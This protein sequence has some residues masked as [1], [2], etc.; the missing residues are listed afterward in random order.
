MTWRSRGFMLAAYITWGIVVGVGFTKLWRYT[1]TPGIEAATSSS[2]PQN[3]R[4]QRA[5]DRPTLVLS[6]SPGCPCSQAAVRELARVVARAPARAAIRMIFDVTSSDSDSVVA[7]Q[8]GRLWRMANDIPGVVT[9]VDRDGSETAAFGANASGQAFLYDAAGR[10]RFRGRIT[11]A[12]G[13]NVDN[14][15]DNGGADSLVALLT[16]SK[17]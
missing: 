1:Y 10:L 13:H 9:V 7:P 16:T 14:G 4:F 3:A 6:V 8:E 5:V 11:T 15:G 12:C 17:E 2:W